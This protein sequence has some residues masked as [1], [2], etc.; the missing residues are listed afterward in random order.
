[1]S[2]LALGVVAALFLLRGFDDN[3][4][5]SW[6]WIFAGTHP[7]ALFGLAAAAVAFAHALARFPLERA[8]A[9]FVFSF[10]AAACFW[11][12]P[13]AIVDASRYFTQAKH[14]EIHGAGYFL[15]QWGKEIPAWTDLPLV[16]F[17]YGLVFRLFGESRICVQAFTTLL[18]TGTVV[19]T[20]RLGKL[21]WNEEAGFAGG[22]LLLAIP[23]LLTQVPAFLADVPTMF[24]FTLAVYATAR[25]CQRGGAAR[26]LLAS[27]AIVPAALSKYSTWIL[28]SVLPVI[29]LVFR[30]PRAG[31]AAFAISGSA[32]LTLLALRADVFSAQAALLAG[33][34]APGL[35]RWGE[36]FASTFLFQIHPF[37]TLAALASLALA[38]RQRDWKAAVVAWPVL[39]LVA[40]Q[41]HRIRY[42]IPVF[43]MLAL[44][45][46]RG[47]QAIRAS[48]VRA[49]VVTSAVCSS[50]AIAG[51]GYLPFLRSTSAANLMAAGAYLDSLEE[52]RVEVLTS[53]RPDAELNEAVDVP[54]LDLFT[55]RK[56][57]Y[58]DRARRPPPGVERS[59]LRF[60]WDYRNPSWYAPEDGP[61]ALVVVISDR[62]G[63][64]PPRG[65]YRLLRVFASD[66]RVFAHTTLVSVYR[67][68][69]KG[70]DI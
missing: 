15:A 41:I 70:G 29:W 68:E 17:L 37:L 51:F 60:T 12:E 42:L 43:P 8:G 24:F 31:L 11:S 59:A 27:A 48:R 65:D 50:L 20:W 49:T 6:S 26:I 36:S 38:A 28:L 9:L 10:A 58:R 44:M 34:Q 64:P 32:V 63:Q 35:G 56:L 13:E 33:Y 46:A 25:A 3:R 4:L 18:F 7:L 53:S 61:A 57:I 22:A 39:L 45:A 40:L 19:L 55:S 1:M 16:P 5:T 21:L 47:L 54:L 69:S 66:E 30:R 67:R 52:P 14:L 2:L 62:P 23:Y